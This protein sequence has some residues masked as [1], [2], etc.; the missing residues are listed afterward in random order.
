M[1]VGLPCVVTNVGDSAVLVGD[2]GVV[3]PKEN[4][5]LLAAAL[6][7]LLRMTPAERTAMGARARERVATH[8]SMALTR[9]RFED[10]YL[11]A[12]DRQADGATN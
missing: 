7:K 5:D 12:K 8:F 9:R 11:A 2:C 10:L 3:V 4:P 1:C 6:L